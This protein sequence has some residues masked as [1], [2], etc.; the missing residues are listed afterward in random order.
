MGVGNTGVTKMHMLASRHATVC[1]TLE[2][3]GRL[4]AVL[5]VRGEARGG[6]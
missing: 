2:S 1:S 5:K 4:S 3:K 6:D